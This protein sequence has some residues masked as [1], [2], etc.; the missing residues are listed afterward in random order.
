[1]AIAAKRDRWQLNP[2]TDP[3]ALHATDSHVCGAILPSAAP[4]LGFPRDAHEGRSEARGRTT[5]CERLTLLSFGPLLTP[6][7]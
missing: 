7:L 2:V 5:R 3:S 1:M 6:L 4:H